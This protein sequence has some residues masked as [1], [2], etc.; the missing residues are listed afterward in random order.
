MV[1]SVRKFRYL[2]APERL[3][4]Q[5]R[6][7]LPECWLG[8]IWPRLLGLIFAASALAGMLLGFVHT[9]ASWMGLNRLQ[10]GPPLWWL[11]VVIPC[12]LYAV[13]S[14]R[15]LLGRLAAEASLE[16]TAL[17]QT[18]GLAASQSGW[19]RGRPVR[20]QQWTALIGGAGL[21]TLCFGLWW[22]GHRLTGEPIDWRT[23]GLL[24]SGQL[25]VVLVAGLALGWRFPILG[26]G[27]LCVSLYLVSLVPWLLA[28]ASG[29]LWSTSDRLWMGWGG[30]QWLLFVSQAALIAVGWVWS[31]RLGLGYLTLPILRPET[32]PPAADPG[33]AA[34]GYQAVVRRELTDDLRAAWWRVSGLVGVAGCCL[35]LS[36]G[37]AFFALDAAW[38]DL[39]PL[40]V[41]LGVLGVGWLGAATFWRLERGAANGGG[42]DSRCVGWRGWWLRQA[43]PLAV[44]AIALVGFTGLALVRST[45]GW[46][47]GINNALPIMGAF[48]CL[49]AVNYAAA[50]WIALQTTSRL[51]SLVMTP[52]AAGLSVNL[53][54]LAYFDLGCSWWVLLL[55]AAIGLLATRLGISAWQTGNWRWSSHALQLALLGICAILPLLEVQASVWRQPTMSSAVAAQLQQ[56]VAEAPPFPIP[57]P[58]KL[59]PIS[60]ESSRSGSLE[61]Q[62]QER[63]GA[64]APL[65][66]LST[67]AAG[68]AALAVGDESPAEAVA[69]AASPELMG[70]L[71]G[72]A[73]LTRPDPNQPS[74]S[75]LHA[76]AVGLLGS[77][78]QRL[79]ASPRLADQEAADTAEMWLIDLLAATPPAALAEFHADPVRWLLPLTDTAHRAAARRRSVAASWKEYL[80]SRWQEES[81]LV[82][83]LGGV[84]FLQMQY[85]LPTWRESAIAHRRLAL[86]VE[87]LWLAVTAD[88]DQQR[89][90]VMAAVER[91]WGAPPGWY[92]VQP[93]ALAWGVDRNLRRLRQHV[94]HHRW[95]GT[96]WHGDWESQAAFKLNA[97]LSDRPKR[98]DTD[99]DSS[100]QRWSLQ[101]AATDVTER[102]GM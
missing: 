41:L 90:S 96:A 57:A 71:M 66:S 6:A 100:K 31:Y 3:Q 69:V 67:L 64:I 24:Q 93:D 53:A 92:A 47:G 85:P 33:V 101:P 80:E 44:L 83:S 34:I 37:V 12:G 25:L 11:L 1:S 51:L 78:A 26:R 98:D 56:A 39:M 65:L 94:F 2:P 73:E 8:P 48:F 86:A 22:L 38:P 23:L 91:A 50:Q 84:Q 4:E 16:T 59:P 30:S 45:Q 89:P 35:V 15:L 72:I 17:G 95:P 75:A 81:R 77:L 29:W 52:V 19:R 68:D 43:P 88:P 62:W 58:L 49:V 13:E 82:V 42:A 18:P 21:A 7:A 70:V 10:T 76:Q 97:W 9:S 28:V 14:A 27:W 74:V 46:P 20:R 5:I 79:R 99:D 36:L 63:L 55:W 54:L 40:A 61:E 87:K 102:R 32:F 60:L